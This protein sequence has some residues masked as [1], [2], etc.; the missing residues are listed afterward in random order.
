MKNY[1]FEKLLNQYIK[2]RFLFFWRNVN[3]FRTN[4]IP[5]NHQIII[6]DTRIFTK[7]ERCELKNKELKNVVNDIYAFLKNEFLIS[8][9]N[10]ICNILENF[11]RYYVQYIGYKQNDNNHYIH[12]NFML[13]KSEKWKTDYPRVLGGGSSF[14]KIEYCIEKRV[15]YDLRINAPR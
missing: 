7:K 9:S 10:N 5:N 4:K 12:C 15:P 8:K 3:F 2:E 11:Y 6:N 14:W 13:Y 1:N